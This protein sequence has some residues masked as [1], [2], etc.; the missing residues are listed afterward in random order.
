MG[1]DRTCAS[2]SLIP[3]S[4]IP[5]GVCTLLLSL[6]LILPIDAHAQ[7][8]KLCCQNIAPY[9]HTT[10]EHIAEVCR[11][12]FQ[13]Q[14]E[15]VRE[16]NRML[17]ERFLGVEVQVPKSPTQ[18][19]KSKK[20][21]DHLQV[22]SE[23]EFGP[24]FDVLNN[25]PWLSE[26]SLSEEERRTLLSNQID[27]HRFVHR[28]DPKVFQDADRDDKRVRIKRL[29]ASASDL[30]RIMSEINKW[31]HDSLCKTSPSLTIVVNQTLEPEIVEVIHEPVEVV[32]VPQPEIVE[33]PHERVV[34][35]ERPQWTPVFIPPPGRE[36][37][38]N[39]VA[40]PPIWSASAIDTSA[41]TILRPGSRDYA[42]ATIPIGVSS[43]GTAFGASVAVAPIRLVK[44]GRTN[45]MLKRRLNDTG[46]LYPK[47]ISEKDKERYIEE[48]MPREDVLDT[49][50]LSFSAAQRLTEVDRRLGI[51]NRSALS[52][53]VDLWD[54]YRGERAAAQCAYRA[55][56]ETYDVR[57]TM[58][59]FKAALAKWEQL[60][61]DVQDEH[62]TLETDAKGVGDAS[63]SVLKQLEGFKL[64]EAI[65]EALESGTEAEKRLQA[66]L[67][68]LPAKGKEVA[69][70]LREALRE[71]LDFGLGDRPLEIV[72]T[73][74]SGN[75][76]QQ[77]A[78]LDSVF[79][80]ELRGC[81]GAEAAVTRNVLG[82]TANAGARTDLDGS[83]MADRFSITTAFDTAN[84]DVAFTA[85]VRLGFYGTLPDVATFTGDRDK[86][87]FHGGF[88]LSVLSPVQFSS[89]ALAILDA[90]PA[91]GGQVASLW[92]GQ[93][94]GAVSVPI[95]GEFRITTSGKI[96][97]GYARLG[98][99][100]GE[101]EMIG[102]VGLG[103]QGAP[104]LEEAALAALGLL[105]KPQ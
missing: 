29:C 67:D 5:A 105:A 48:V 79:A 4:P 33:I 91:Y 45:G 44:M 100:H 63:T 11:E 16:V 76:P 104:K 46:R 40:E 89:E 96:R 37:R 64:V 52:V 17:L 32:E 55:A 22:I 43:A 30:S 92:G 84:E 54:S 87:M 47:G 101:P 95:A 21:V 27:E 85:L 88:R 1:C 73:W 72:R 23:D 70:E 34:V 20:K 61:L 14:P 2:R 65:V 39:E 60:S 74:K 38:A 69:A 24:T 82:V 6:T 98:L 3:A 97:L 66:R 83:L 28:T 15:L 12:R 36:V 80:D 49:L 35:V 41:L 8:T 94:G 42:D 50:Q 78:Y 56:Q 53:S 71:S 62:H 10:V 31:A 19:C 102:L 81:G 86:V 103:W 13:E 57:D 9:E 59:R 26:S 68:Q 18:K 75:T 99:P 90:L 25:L 7:G 77:M 93:F 51:F 58:N